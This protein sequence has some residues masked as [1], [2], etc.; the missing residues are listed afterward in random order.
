MHRPGSISLSFKS[1]VLIPVLAF[2]VLVPVVTLTMMQRRVSAQFER[3]AE[4]KLRTAERIFQSYLEKRSG[5]LHARYRNLVEEPRFMAIAKLIAE[6]K[7]LSAVKTTADD[8]LK[9]TFSDEDA[10][11]TL[12]TTTDGAIL[13]IS[14][15]PMLR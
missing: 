14:R 4:R 2:L 10:Q 15:D 3:D 13:P 5:F 1:K 12:F 11:V 9:R 8:F 7:N 6:A